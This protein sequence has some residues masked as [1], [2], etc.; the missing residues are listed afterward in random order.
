MRYPISCP[1]KT[2]Y[3]GET[4]PKKLFRLACRGYFV[5]RRKFPPRRIQKLFREWSG[6]QAEINASPK[7]QWLIQCGRA[8]DEGPEALAKFKAEN[9]SPWGTVI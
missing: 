2:L 3:S 4:N 1:R 6:I 8:D 9:P 7:V 5:T